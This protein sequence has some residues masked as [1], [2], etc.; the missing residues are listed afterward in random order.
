MGWIRKLCGGRIRCWGERARFVGAHCR[1]G[2]DRGVLS[3]AY[4]STEFEFGMSHEAM[5]AMKA[6]GAAMMKTVWIDS[7]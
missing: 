5:K 2:F 7:A 3:C 1:W 6:I 4:R